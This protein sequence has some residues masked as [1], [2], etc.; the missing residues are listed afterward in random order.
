M[1]DTENQR[2]P[3]SL[4]PLHDLFFDVYPAHRT[5]IGLL[6]V[7]MLSDDFEVSPQAIRGWFSC[8]K[9]PAKRV[10]RAIELSKNSKGKPRLTLD[11]LKPF[12]FK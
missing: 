5:R 3:G 12:V 4:G 2:R 6:S 11:L 1:T 8:N 7:S 10:A 9:L